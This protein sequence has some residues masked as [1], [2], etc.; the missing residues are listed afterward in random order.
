MFKV[1]R[2]RFSGDLEELSSSNPAIF[3]TEP[4]DID[5]DIY[6][7]TEETF[8]IENG[9]HKG[10]LQ[11]QTSSLPSISK[12]FLPAIHSIKTSTGSV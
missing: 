3:E 4:I 5:D 6:Y 12:V 9:L 8:Y 10:N 1:Y 7:E 11:D 2:E